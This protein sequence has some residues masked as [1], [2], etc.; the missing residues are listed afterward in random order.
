MTRCDSR[1][2]EKCEETQFDAHALERRLERARALLAAST[3]LDAPSPVVGAIVLRPDQVETVHR[4]RTLLRRD[5]GCL[6]ADDVGT[7]KTFVALAAAREWR[8]P[9][10]VV[11]ASLR[12][13]WQQAARRADVRCAF[14]T[15]EGL[16]RG[17]TLDEDFDGIV[18]DESHRFRPTSRRHAALACLAAR[19]PLLMLSATPMQNRARE[20]AAQLALFLGEVAYV[21]EPAQLTRWVVRSAPPAE[22][23]LPRVVPPRWLPVE[24]DDADVLREI[25]ALPP[26]PRAADAGDGGVLLQLSLV[27]AWASSR[28]A[29]VTTLRRRQRT[30]AA[31]EQCHEERRL[32][33]TRELQSWTASGDVQ[34]GFPSLLASGAVDGGR[35]AALG[36]AIERERSALDALLRTID[37]AG[38]VDAK[39]V[40]ALSAVRRTHAGESMLAFSE[41]RSTVH[42]FWLALRSAPGIGMLSASE[43]RIASG[44]VTRDE[45]LARFA[46]RA[47]GHRAPASH[48]R[49]TLLLTTDVLSE[50]VNLQDASV[51]VHLDLPWNPARLGQRVGRIRR[52]G[53]A[54]AV[55]S[56]LMS[57]PAH[58]A[59]LLQAEKRLRDKLARA[60]RTIGRSVGVLPMLGP[61]ALAAASAHGGDALGESSAT[62][63]SAAEIRGEIARRLTRWRS[64]SGP[65]P[66][67]LSDV[68][69]IVAVCAPCRGWVALL[70]DGRLVAADADRERSRTPSD[71]PEAILRALDLAGGAP[72]GVCNAE[73]DEAAHELAEW[74]ARDWTQ[75]SSGLGDVDTVMRRRVRRAID[76][77]LRTTP[78]H[79]RAEI[80]RCVATLRD[81]LSGPLPL[82]VERAL[83]TLAAER[84]T[85]NDWI[86]SAAAV[87]TRTPTEK[88]S[89]ADRAPRRCRVLILFGGENY[90]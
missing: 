43:T 73:R 38:D 33:T 31:I 59:L 12:S 68:P 74:I 56:Y 42:A 11:P 88:A 79:R 77:A 50:G 55:A 64:T 17:R 51:V 78:R 72:R 61:S 7:G 70:D 81:A 13:T 8:R 57:P 76:D 14:A 44:R 26:P 28:A 37:A 53:G 24:A 19:T 48:E 71:S 58:A 65:Y 60:E 16:S 34:L 69:I 3:V 54:D 52:P 75:R 83:D 80:L 5:G 30:L 40:G 87:A 36:H 90:H 84:A 62:S 67:Q 4:V 82:G 45:L 6:L 18:V 27:R 49:V 25:L 86:A 47:Q 1:E 63:W 85:R 39:R 89:A 2:A 15:H 20:L 23:R 35:W 32:P 41:F 10:I 29:L 46:P 66:T 21:L 22:L 9:L